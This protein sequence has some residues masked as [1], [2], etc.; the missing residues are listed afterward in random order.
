MIQ[1]NIVL[2][3]MIVLGTPA[4]AL[5]PE[6]MTQSTEVPT[7][8]SYGGTETRSGFILMSIKVPDHDTTVS[9]YGGKLRLYDVHLAK[10]FEVSHFLCQRHRVPGYEWLYAAGNGRLSMGQ[11]QISCQQAQQI[12]TRYG[13]GAPERTPIERDTEGGPPEFDHYQIPILDITGTKVNP[14]LEFVQNFRPLD[15]RF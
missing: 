7:R 4:T 11:F 15:N 2:G 6:L 3:L 1:W 12:A 5:P 13:L 8:I 9:A 14:W 10:M